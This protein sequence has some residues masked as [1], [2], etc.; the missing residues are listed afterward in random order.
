MVTTANDLT[1][2]QW[3]AA[4]VTDNAPWLFDP[5]TEVRR[6]RDELAV[7]IARN[8]VNGLV[9]DTSRFE[10]ADDLVTEFL[11]CATKKDEHQLLAQAARGEA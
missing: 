5:I 3:V 8:E 6:F 2:R 4:Y 11:D 7:E 10:A 9:S 1:D